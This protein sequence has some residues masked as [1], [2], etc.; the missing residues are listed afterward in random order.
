M[1]WAVAIAQDIRN[2]PSATTT[3]AGRSPVTRQPRPVPVLAI[4]TPI[5]RCRRGPPH[6]AIS[7]PPVIMP[8]ASASAICATWLCVP[9]ESTS[10][11]I[12][13]SAPA[14]NTLPTAK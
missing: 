2:T 8:A 13:T 1:P 12:R 9:N 4:S 6:S 10:E 3:M 7:R 14:R 5:I 11:A